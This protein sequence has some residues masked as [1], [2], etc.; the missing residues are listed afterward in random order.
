MSESLLIIIGRVLLNSLLQAEILPIE[1]KEEAFLLAR[2]MEAL[3]LSLLVQH[4]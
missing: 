1:I 2:K 3:L 4:D